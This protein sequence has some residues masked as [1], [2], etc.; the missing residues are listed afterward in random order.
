MKFRSGRPPEQKENMLPLINVVFLLLI[1]FML[2]AN[3]STYVPFPVAPPAAENVTDGRPDIMIA[4]AADGRVALD[5]SEME[6]A[7]LDARLRPRL[8][9]ANRPAVWLYADRNVDSDRVLDVMEHL[10]KAGATEL[11]LVTER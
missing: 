5:G 6:T 4:V 1:F 11:R 9:K 3:I 2:L 10:R 8:V 7:A